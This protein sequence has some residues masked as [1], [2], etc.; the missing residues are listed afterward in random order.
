MNFSVI[1]RTAVILL[2]AGLASSYTLNH[3]YV[4]GPYMQDSGWFAYLSA[5]ASQWPASNPPAIGGTYFSTHFSPA[6]YLGS[7][8]YAGIVALGITLFDPVWFALS[9]G[10]WF[11]IIVAASLMLLEDQAS[12]G[13]LALLVKSTLALLIGFNGIALAILSYPHFEIAIPALFLAFFALEQKGY[14]RTAVLSLT[15]GLLMREDAGF[16]YF[17]FLILLAIALGRGSLRFSKDRREPFFLAMGFFCLGYSL[18]ILFLQ[19]MLF[20]SGDNAMAR[21]Y[22][23]DPPLAHLSWGFMKE[24]LTFASAHRLYILAPL[25]LLAMISFFRRSMVLILG[26]IA[27]L[28]WL[29]LNLMAVAALPGNLTSHYPF[30]L[31]ISFFWPLIV[32]SLFKSLH[33]AKTTSFWKRPVFLDVGLICLISITA[34]AFDSRGNADSA[35]WKHF[36]PAWMGHIERSHSALEGF[37]ASNREIHFIVDD[38]VASLLNEK[39]TNR[40]WRNLLA[41]TDQDFQD[42]DA[43]LFQKNAWLSG[44]IREVAR[45]K[46]YHFPCRLGETGLIALSRKPNLSGCLSRRLTLEQP[47]STQLEDFDLMPG[48]GGREDSGRWTLGDQVMLPEIDP[49]RP[50]LLC[51]KG[52]GYLPTPQSRISVEFSIPGKRQGGFSYDPQNPEGERCVDLPAGPS[53]PAPE[54]PFKLKIEGATSPFSLGLSEDQRMLGVLIEKIYLK[55]P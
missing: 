28:P 54:I 44:K 55:K 1:F 20:A 48:W 23:G 21:V 43:I 46:G 31:M 39:V 3:F 45:E 4:Q 17:G 41:F 15:L 49:V 5:H 16:H 52:R 8:L 29:A 51:F 37:F 36:A 38:S 2:A 40:Q 32:H 47:L 12:G 35:P 7:A 50:A 42:I 34:Y 25:M 53:S 33:P 14:R 18:I 30:P 19:K 13:I 6:F 26:V 9:Q 11:A 24:R 22:L 27:A 10:L